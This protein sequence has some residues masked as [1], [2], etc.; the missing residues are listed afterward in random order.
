MSEDERIPVIELWG[1]LLVPFQ[2]DVTDHQANVLIESVLSRVRRDACTGVALDLSGLSVV[3]SHLC[4]AFAGLAAAASYMG[5]RTVLCGLTP[6]I[7]MTLETMGVELRGVDV[8]LSLEH[9]L[10]RLG[11]R[12]PGVGAQA[13]RAEA[14]ALAD[15][16]VERQER[17]GGETTAA[18]GG[19]R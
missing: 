1:V 16:M 3:D 14:W 18:E 13:A 17:I 12:P 2:G 9:A 15:A 10:D 4:A 19:A 11:L 8:V 7:A 5:A 6:E